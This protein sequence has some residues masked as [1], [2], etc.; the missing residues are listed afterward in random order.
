MLQPSSATRSGRGARRASAESIPEARRRPALLRR[1]SRRPTLRGGACG[2]DG[3]RLRRISSRRLPESSIRSAR[4]RQSRSTRE[5]RRLRGRCGTLAP[6]YSS[7]RAVTTRRDAT[8]ARRT[9]RDEPRPASTPWRCASRSLRASED[10]SDSASG[11]RRACARG[12][13]RGWHADHQ[14]AQQR[15][16]SHPPRRTARRVRQSDQACRLVKPVWW[17]RR[18]SRWQR[19]GDATSRSLADR[20]SAASVPDASTACRA[21]RC[22]SHRP[23]HPLTGSAS[24]CRSRAGRRSRLAGALRARRRPLAVV[25]RA[26]AAPSRSRRRELPRTRSLR[27]AAPRV[28]AD[29][30]RPAGLARFSGVA[31]R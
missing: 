23:P 4:A 13:T 31:P 27:S 28:V 22:S 25:G 11:V 3:R 30:K 19:N 29:Y 26:S 7:T 24:S 15:H 10:P 2:G 9:R 5:R 17:R 20:I 12:A 1:R 21:P 6:S 14:T 16:R 18:R 8:A